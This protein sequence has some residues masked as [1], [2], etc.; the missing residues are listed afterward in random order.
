MRLRVLLLPA[1]L[2]LLARPAPAPAAE[3]WIAVVVPANA[4]A[5]PDA[6]ELSLIFK[7]KKLYDDDGGRLQPI[8]LPADSPIRRRFSRAVLRLTPEAM[9]DYWNQMYY[10][11]VL[12]PHVVESEAAMIRFVAQTPH[13]IGYVAAC[14]SS[15][16]AL[17]VV[18]L[19]DAEGHV[20]PAGPVP[21]CP[22]PPR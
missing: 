1:L 9:D 10:Q 6:S 8:N 2:L 18:L 20:L 3:P 11:G 17:R 15:D 7:R 13:A 4:E 12:P 21:G 5:A 16:A 22:A 19:I 14:L